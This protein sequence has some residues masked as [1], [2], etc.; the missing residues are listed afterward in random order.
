MQNLCKHE[1]TSPVKSFNIDIE[2]NICLAY[3]HYVQDKKINIMGCFLYRILKIRA[4]YLIENAPSSTYYHKIK[5]ISKYYLESK[6]IMNHGKMHYL[7]KTQKTKLLKLPMSLYAL[8]I[9]V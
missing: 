8:V 6:Q 3:R 7:Q 1:N 9:L 2:H 5:I 4:F